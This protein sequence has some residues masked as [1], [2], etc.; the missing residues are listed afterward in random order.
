[1]ESLEILGFYFRI[2]LVNDVGVLSQLFEDIECY[3]LKEDSRGKVGGFLLDSKIFFKKR[4][5]S[6]YYVVVVS[7]DFVFFSVDFRFI[8]FFLKIFFGVV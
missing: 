2:C 1:M 8:Q 4:N 7:G 6:F 3:F 5:I